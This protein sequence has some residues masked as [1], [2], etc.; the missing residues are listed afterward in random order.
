M[1][2][3]PYTPSRS[4]NGP[5]NSQSSSG[6]RRDSTQEDF[7]ALPQ[8]RRDFNAAF[9]N[10]GAND[11]LSRARKPY[12]PL[13]ITQ[14]TS[15]IAA[16]A[17]PPPWVDPADSWR[18]VGDEVWTESEFVYAPRPAVHASTTFATPLPGSAQDPFAGRTTP[19]NPLKNSTLTHDPVAPPLQSG[20]AAYSSFYGPQGPPTSGLTHARQSPPAAGYNRASANPTPAS[21][22]ST[23][24]VM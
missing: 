5:N 6:S 1:S 19:S 2:N 7:T 23:G 16:P 17:N 11:E 22:P 20:T 4:N 8:D 24:P 18:Y 21:L 12:L 3:L 10:A 9:M 14:P 15:Y 13:L